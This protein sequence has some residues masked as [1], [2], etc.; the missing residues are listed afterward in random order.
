MDIEVRN[1]RDWPAERDGQLVVA[2]IGGSGIGL[3]GGEAGVAVPVLS[4]FLG[5]DIDHPGLGVAV[6]GLEAAGDNVDLFD[7]SGGE[8]EG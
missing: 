5:D 6:L 4:A 1:R 3:I 8:F 2:V 7:C